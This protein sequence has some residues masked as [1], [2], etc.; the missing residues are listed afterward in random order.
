MLSSTGLDRSKRD[1]AG[2]GR[3]SVHMSLI[4]SVV[5]SLAAIAILSKRH[6][7]DYLWVHVAAFVIPMPIALYFR[8]KVWRVC[9]STSSKRVLLESADG[10][11]S[12]PV[13]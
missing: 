6:L 4:L 10:A 1:A 5:V 12:K 3:Y 2:V 11:F 8:N 9:P 13:E 7:T